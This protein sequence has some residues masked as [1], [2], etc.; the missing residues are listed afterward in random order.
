MTLPHTDNHSVNS[1]LQCVQVQH[2]QQRLTA[3]AQAT[4]KLACSCFEQQEGGDKKED[5]T[6]L[7]SPDVTFFM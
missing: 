2:L 1:V 3:V 5:Y 6:L 4:S 7:T